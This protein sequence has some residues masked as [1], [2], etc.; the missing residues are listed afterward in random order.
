MRGIWRR[1]A[2]AAVVLTAG[3]G[4]LDPSDIT[5]SYQ[6]V[7][8]RIELN[9]VVTDMLG[10]GASVD[11]DVNPDG[12]LG[13]RLVVPAVGGVQ[14]F[15]ID[16]ATT[17]TYTIHSSDVLLFNYRSPSGYLDELRFTA[18]PPQLN[19]YVVIQRSG[20]AGSFTLTLRRQ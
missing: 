10:R 8:F 1:M 16:A 3:C 17:G 9:G 11:L 2:L 20:E 4:S 14:L 5:G 15:P 6:A 12:T 7:Q 13:G 18:N 19:A